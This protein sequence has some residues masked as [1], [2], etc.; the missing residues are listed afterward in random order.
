MLMQVITILA[1]IAIPA[2]LIGVM[3][4]WFLRP[5]RQLAAAPQIARDPPMVAAVYYALPVLIIAGV[6]RLL[7]AE[8]LDFSAVLL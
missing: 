8:D 1:W 2:T 5:R 4:D 7:S 6:V 3:D